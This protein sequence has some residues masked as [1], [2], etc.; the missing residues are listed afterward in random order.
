MEDSQK[1]QIKKEID[2]IYKRAE[3][4]EH[5]Q[6][7]LKPL[8]EAYLLLSKDERETKEGVQ[9]FKKVMYHTMELKKLIDQPRA[10]QYLAF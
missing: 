8:Y 5:H 4:F 9:L 10:K 6:K 7:A 2:H 3:E 1:E